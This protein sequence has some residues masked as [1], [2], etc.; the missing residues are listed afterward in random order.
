ML[1]P[2][3]GFRAPLN[4][5]PI[6]RKANRVRGFIDILTIALPAVICGS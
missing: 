4:R 1:Q 2:L 5:R 3:W 6:A